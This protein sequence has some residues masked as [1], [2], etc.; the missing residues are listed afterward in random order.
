MVEVKNGSRGARGSFV[1]HYGIKRG[2]KVLKRYLNS[3]A[4][5]STYVYVNTMLEFRFA[6]NVHI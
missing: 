2:A 3:P 5:L 1:G 6:T 4:T